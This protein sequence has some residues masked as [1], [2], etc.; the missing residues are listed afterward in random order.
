MRAAFALSVDGEVR[1]VWTPLSERGEAEMEAIARWPF[2]A[3]HI[4]GAT[5][6]VRVD[7]ICYWYPPGLIS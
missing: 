3:D 5:E 1:I 6:R 7:D 4:R 2:L